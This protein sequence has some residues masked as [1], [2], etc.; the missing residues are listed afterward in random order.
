[1][2]L[3]RG[4]KNDIGFVRMQ[5][6]CQSKKK[7]F[8][9]VEKGNGFGYAA[10]VSGKSARRR[11]PW[12][13]L[14]RLSE[15]SSRLTCLGEWV[16]LKSSRPPGR[17]TPNSGPIT[18]NGTDTF[19]CLAP[20]PAWPKAD[21]TDALRKVGLMARINKTKGFTLVE[22]L[23]VIGIIALLI[24]I[25]LPSLN[26]ARETANRVK[27][28]SNLRQIGQAILL[29]SNENKGAYPRTYYNS[30]ASIDTGGINT[31]NNGYS[32]SDPFAAGA[33][34]GTVATTATSTDV[35]GNNVMS[36]LF[37]LLRTEDIGSEV[38]T[39]PSSNA[40]KDDFGGGSNTAQNRANFTSITTNLSY[41]YANPFPSSTALGSGYKL[42]NSLSPD[43]AVAAD[44]NPG[45]TGTGN[46]VTVVRTASPS[47]Q[48]RY[49][50]SNNHDRD[51]QNVLYGDGRVEFQQSPFVGVNRDNI[52]TRSDTTYS[53]GTANTSGTVTFTSSTIAASPADAN[54][55]IL[56]P[57]DDN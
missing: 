40:T 39:C 5:V 8:A 23:V 50:N 6:A 3:G 49:G 31:S 46:L 42:N 18:R 30:T 56:L 17:R 32:L 12:I 41:S 21:L 34:T 44:M 54:D 24:S 35:G 25:L 10:A 4:F 2:T 47:S 37:L 28:A 19:I 27:C 51:G 20:T 29:Y 13:F 45:I 14:Q 22:L 1:M 43:F 57:T 48:M 52:F 55:S 26:R 53:N 33:T 16:E 15:R 7:A 36:S 11:S 38:F 9:Q